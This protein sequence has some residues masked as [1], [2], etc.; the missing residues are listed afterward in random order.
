MVINLKIKIL[1]PY[2]LKLHDLSIETRFL[3]WG[4]PEGNLLFVSITGLLPYLL[5]PLNNSHK[6]TPVI[7]TGLKDAFSA[8][9]WRQTHKAIPQYIISYDVDLSAEKKCSNRLG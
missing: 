9:N 1:L 6:T 3:V 7:P 2:Y 4:K 8:I 5:F